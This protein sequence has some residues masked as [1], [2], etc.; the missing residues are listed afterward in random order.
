MLP[1]PNCGRP[2]DTRCAIVPAHTE[3]ASER[4]GGVVRECAMSTR[5]MPR[6]VATGK[7]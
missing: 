4:S 2:L 7:T 3:H 1:C 6:A 5:P